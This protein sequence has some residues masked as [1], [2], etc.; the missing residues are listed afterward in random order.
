MMQMLIWF[1]GVALCGLGLYILI[2][3]LFLY[4]EAIKSLFCEKEG[5]DFFIFL[6]V[7][8]LFDA[9]GVGIFYFGYC[10]MEYNL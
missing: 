8:F 4:K 6:L 2:S 3:S 1:A 5:L 7:A 9:F 10:V